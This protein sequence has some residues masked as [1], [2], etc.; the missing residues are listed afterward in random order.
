MPRVAKNKT[1]KAVVKKKSVKKEK[2][3]AN[4]KG[5]V[6]VQFQN[7]FPLFKKLKKRFGMTGKALIINALEH[8][9]ATQKPLLQE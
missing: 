3:V 6:S 1:G 5:S 7:K 8:Y 9:E 2:P 4:P